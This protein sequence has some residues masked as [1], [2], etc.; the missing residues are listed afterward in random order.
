[1]NTISDHEHIESWFRQN[2][3]AVRSVSGVDPLFL[4]NQYVWLVAS[5]GVDLFTQVLEREKPVG[6]RRFLCHL[7]KGQI[8]ANWPHEPAGEESTMRMLASG[9]PGTELIAVDTSTFYFQLPTEKTLETAIE[10]WLDLLLGSLSTTRFQGTDL[11]SSINLTSP[12]KLMKGQTLQIEEATSW[13]TI[14]EGDLEAFGADN[15]IFIAGDTLPLSPKSFVTAS[16]DALVSLSAQQKLVD[17]G[18]IERCMDRFQTLIQQYLEKRDHAYQAQ[19]LLR[20]DTKERHARSL[21]DNALHQL[22]NV[23][24]EDESELVKFTNID[25]GALLS[26][27]QLVAAQLSIKITDGL[28]VDAPSLQLTDMAQHGLDLDRI[29]RASRFRYRRVVLKDKWWQTDSGPLLAFLEGSFEPV[30]LIPESS[31][32]Y[33]LVYPNQSKIERV[34]ASIAEKLTGEAFMFYRHL[35]EHALSLKDLMTFVVDR[36]LRRDLRT[37]LWMGIF[38][39]VL[40]MITPI[41]TGIIFDQIIPGAQ[42]PQMFQIMFGLLAIAFGSGLF[43]ITRAIAIA[44]IEGRSDSSLQAAVWNRLLELPAPFF[45]QF[46]AGELAERAMGISRMRQTL[47]AYTVGALM[48]VLFASFN[49]ALLFYYNLQLAL[50]AIAVVFVGLVVTASCGISQMKYQEQISLISQNISG[51]VLQF[52]SGVT[53]LRISGTESR[54][55]AMWSQKFREQKR[56]PLNM[57]RIQNRLTVFNSAYPVI[58]SIVIFGFY[59]YQIKQAFLTKNPD[60]MTTGDFVAFNAAFGAF[61]TAMISASE[62]LIASLVVIPMYKRAQPILQALPEVDT[63]KLQPPRLHGSIE[64]NQLVFRYSDDGPAVLDDISLEIKEGE[65][66]AVVGSSG[67][68]KSTLFRLLLGFEKAESGSIFYDHLDLSSL[69]IRSVRKQCGVVLQNAQLMAGDVFANIVGNNSALSQENAWEAARMSGLAEDIRA[70]PMGMQTVISEGGG[71]F[72]GGQ[73]QRLVIA[74]AVVHHPKIIFFDEATSA[75]DNRTLAIVSES[76]EK[77]KA[78]RVVIAHRLSTIRN[79]DRIFV[80]DSGKVAEQGDYDT[81]MTKNGLFAELAKRQLT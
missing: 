37:I 35:P 34:N 44:R 23:L 77:L 71:G 8:L 64:V 21:M 45:R 6:A 12:F 47:S 24:E 55:F 2:H 50:V 59:A 49:L 69:D 66:V 1:M 16:S 42:R 65:F 20:L 74:R 30:A 29:S 72:S 14:H 9:E 58:A 28:K 19:E 57:R 13:L 56:L 18:S 80:L 51:M 10:R 41:A 79:A 70:L 67:S 27:C 63:A 15:L 3:L 17:D 11:Q 43:L 39:G 48:G 68:G 36:T 52:I 60:V 26:A 40:G 61:V 46:S 32:I 22:A 75:L 54:A 31:G 62:A 33:N 81:L 53:K 78:T 73:K 7:E 4:D 5:E 76:L 38:G 25:S